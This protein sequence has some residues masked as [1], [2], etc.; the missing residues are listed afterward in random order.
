MT[1]VSTVPAFNSYFSLISSFNSPWRSYVKNSQKTTRKSRQR[2][3]GKNSV[4]KKSVLSS[5]S[6]IIF[7]SSRFLSPFYSAFLA[8]MTGLYHIFVCTK[9]IRRTHT[10]THAWTKAA[11]RKRHGRCFD[12]KPAFIPACQFTE[13]TQYNQSYL[14][15]A[16]P[17]CYSG[18]IP[19]FITAIIC[20]RKYMSSSNHILFFPFLTSAQSTYFLSFIPK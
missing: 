14:I 2:V 18:L 1:L 7:F 11:R 13:A 10:H 5:R 17:I 6:L 12:V 15:Q 3:I 20:E 8:V 19:F 9:P 4:F 16:I